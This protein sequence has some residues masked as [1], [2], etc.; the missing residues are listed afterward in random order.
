M[1]IGIYSPYFNAMGGGERYVLSLAMHWSKYHE[2]SLFWSD[3]AIL[4]LTKERLNIDLSNISVKENIFAKNKANKIWDTRNYDLIFIL[5]D[6]SI[7][8][9]LAKR[10]ILHFQRPFSRINGHSWLNRIKLTRY[11][12]I[13]CNS[14][15]TKKYIEREYSVEPS[16]IYPPVMTSA[17]KPG[18]KKN[19]IL[20]VGRFGETAYKKQIEMVKFFRVLSKRLKGWE[21]CLIGGVLPEDEDFI[22]KLSKEAVGLNVTI[23]Q[24]I[25]FSEIKKYYSSALIYWH[26]AGYGETD[27]AFFEHFGIS[28]VE[29]M[30]SGCIP[31]VYDAGGQTEIV[32]DGINGF[33]WHT[34]DELVQKTLD[35]ANHSDLYKKI[36]KSAQLRALSFDEKIFY[37]DFDKLFADLF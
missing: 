5:S 18:N 22:S 10:N 30:A 33:T 32:Q 36:S 4:D 35:I 24:N 17:Y 14:F 7:P 3:Q 16:V 21:F 19:F 25:P 26:A 20:S 12:K 9:S 1:K 34:P 13:V 6:G 27:P 28:T 23:L 29:A 37:Q 11:Q 15:F 31:V 2:V 8:L